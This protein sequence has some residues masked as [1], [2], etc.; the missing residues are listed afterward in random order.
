M[1]P[2]NTRRLIG[3][4]GQSGEAAGKGVAL[5]EVVIVS[6]AS[7]RCRMGTFYRD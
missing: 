7:Y 4:Y 5:A 6:S 3:C 2:R 1:F